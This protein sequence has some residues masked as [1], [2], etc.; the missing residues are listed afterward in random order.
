M[1]DEVSGRS[2]E[3]LLDAPAFGPVAALSRRH[4]GGVVAALV[5]AVAALLLVRASGVLHPDRDLSLPP[6]PAAALVAPGIV[7]GGQPTE[8]DLVR[9]RDDFGVRAVVAVGGASVEERAVTRGLGVA[10]L[11]L[12]V[13]DSVEPPAAV[14]LALIRFLR[15]VDPA[16]GRDGGGIVYVHDLTGTGPVVVVAAMLQLLSGQQLSAVLAGLDPGELE[17]LGTPELVA[18]TE[19]AA[20]A[21]GD[22]GAAGEYRALVGTGL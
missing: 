17:G 13:A 14:L 2:S 1:A 16:A 10:L 18:L 4:R 9:L 8:L 3:P 11:E 5:V 22:G 7:R 19:V 15:Q 20:A 21:R 6:V 12:D